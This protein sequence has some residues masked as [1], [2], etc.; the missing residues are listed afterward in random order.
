MSFRPSISTLFIERS[1]C[2]ASHT[3]RSYFKDLIVILCR[4][5]GSR[6]KI[7][8]SQ[9][10]K[11]LQ[12]LFS[13]STSTY[14]K[15]QERILPI[16]IQSTHTEPLAVKHGR[17]PYMTTRV[18]HAAVGPAWDTLVGITKSQVI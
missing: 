2:E 12:P 4:A 18:S 14:L 8:F 15:K 13:E 3:F 1:F 10:T 9:I 7:L 5:K 17:R 6:A 11:H 16:Q